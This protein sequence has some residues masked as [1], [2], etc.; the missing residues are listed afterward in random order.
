MAR[1]M[2][3][4]PEPSGPQGIT[5][6]VGQHTALHPGGRGQLRGACPFCGSTAFVVRPAHGTFHCFRCGEG[7]DGPAFTAKIGATG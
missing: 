6:L 5:E 3:P 7:G 2:L 1:T 4:A